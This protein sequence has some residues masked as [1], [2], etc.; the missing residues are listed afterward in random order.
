MSIIPKPSKFSL[1]V[2]QLW[3]PAIATGA[4]GA[5]LVH[6]FEDIIAITLEF[7]GVFLLPILV[8][9]IYIF[10]IFLFKSYGLKSKD[11]KS[12]ERLSQ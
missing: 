4:S 11:Q 8:A 6:W 3:K 12:K 10:N 5:A 7:I 2:H 1:R 9:I